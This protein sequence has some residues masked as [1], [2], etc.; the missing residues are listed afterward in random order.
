MSD[1]KTIKFSIFKILLK[2][3]FL[4]LISMY[5]IYAQSFAATTTI[6]YAGTANDLSDSI[7]SWTNVTN[8]IENT[9][10]TSTNNILRA[11]RVD[12]NTLSLT[13]FNLSAAG[14]PA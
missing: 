5:F 8:A 1:K 7:M 2:S 11:R 13:N 4:P 12:S 6:S 10:G 3:T 9:T 14:V